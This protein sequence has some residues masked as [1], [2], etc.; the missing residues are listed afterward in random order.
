MTPLPKIPLNRKAL[1]RAG[2]A[3]IGASQTNSVVRVLVDESADARLIEAG[4]LFLIPEQDCV[5]FTVQSFSKKPPEVTSAADLTIVLA[6][7]SPDLGRLLEIALWTKQTLV[8]LSPEPQ[9]LLAQVHDADTAAAAAH[10]LKFDGEYPDRE[11]AIRHLQDDLA[12]WIVTRL[13]N[14]RLNLGRAFAFVRPV[15]IQDLGQQAALENAVIAAVF[16]L[17]GADMPALTLNQLKLLYQ[18]A[19]LNGLPL[20]RERLPAVV[21]VVVAGFVFRALSRLLTRR[22]GLVNWLVR[23]A[24][25]ALATLAIGRLGAAFYA[26]GGL[27]NQS[28][29]QDKAA[30]S[31][32]AGASRG[33]LP[34]GARQKSPGRPSSKAEASNV[35][36]GKAEARATLPDGAETP[37]VPADRDPSSSPT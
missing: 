2:R 20:G 33:L 10:I 32:A 1:A 8:I 11:E 9:N 22:S 36:V 5:D 23:A 28:T 3:F 25:A 26:P 18:I 37:H 27:L 35:S 24:V 13:P 19:L 31:D 15:V 16:F 7:S 6:G 12:R 14:Q 17:P 30:T 29:A 21:S 34:A 4:R